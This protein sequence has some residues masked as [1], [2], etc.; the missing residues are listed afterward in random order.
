MTVQYTLHIFKLDTYIETKAKNYI[1]R[2]IS[3]IR[4]RNRL[5]TLIG[6]LVFKI[7]L[8]LPLHHVLWL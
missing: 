2:L 6:I 1:V 7:S 3:N 5:S 4:Y 8:S